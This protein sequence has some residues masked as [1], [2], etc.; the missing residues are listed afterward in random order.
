MIKKKRT[1]QWNTKR[2]RREK[3][4]EKRLC[5]FAKWRGQT[6]LTFDRTSKQ[7]IQNQKREREGGRKRKIESD[8]EWKW[9]KESEWEKESKCERERER[10]RGRDPGPF[11][12]TFISE[13]KGIHFKFPGPVTFKSKGH[14]AC[15]TP[16]GISLS[17]S[18]LLKLRSDWSADV[19][20]DEMMQI[21]IKDRDYFQIDLFIVQ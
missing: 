21:D 9:E 1:N 19:T 20:F 7:I 4:K 6:T 14:R 2:E 5:C 10:G 17:G 18:K 3:R 15:V 11:K 13:G 12:I 8:K 16:Q